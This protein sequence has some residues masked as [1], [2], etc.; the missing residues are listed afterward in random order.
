[1]WKVIVKGIMWLWPLVKKDIV[2]EVVDAVVREVSR[3]VVKSDNTLDDAAANKLA[4]NKEYIKDK[5]T[6]LL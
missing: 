6:E 2:N 5:L 4:E 3:A 1:M